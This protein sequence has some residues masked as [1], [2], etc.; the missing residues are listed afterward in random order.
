MIPC[1]VNASGH[2]GLSVELVVRVFEAKSARAEKESKVS[3]GRSHVFRRLR[4]GRRRRAGH[5]AQVVQV[6]VQHLRGQELLLL[7]L[8]LA[9]KLVATAQNGL[10]QTGGGRGR[11]ERGRGRRRRS[12]RRWW[13][14]RRFGLRRHE[15]SMSTYPRHKAHKGASN[16][17]FLD[18]HYFSQGVP[19]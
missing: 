11:C 3:P 9:T 2:G 16:F 7:L 8:L 10:L 17:L 1:G 12:E 18:S 6:V 14:L 5:G 4:L 15:S 19:Q 13:R